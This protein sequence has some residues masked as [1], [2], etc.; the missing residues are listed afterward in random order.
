MHSR[1]VEKWV[2]KEIGCKGVI[3]NCVVQD[4]FKIWAVVKTVMSIRIITEEY[5]DR[6]SV[7]ERMDACR[8]HA[9]CLPEIYFAGFTFRVQK[10]NDYISKQGCYEGIS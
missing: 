1:A 5:L 6:P 9:V 3:C 10:C 8:N 2:L 4:R 7:T